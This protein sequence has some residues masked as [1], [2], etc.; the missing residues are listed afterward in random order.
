MTRK[1]VFLL[2][3]LQKGEG[4]LKTGEKEKEAGSF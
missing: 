1:K 4:C 2:H 3:A